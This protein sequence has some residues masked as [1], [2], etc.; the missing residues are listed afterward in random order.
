MFN[1]CNRT[2]SRA[3]V[4]V[5]HPTLW[6]RASPPKAGRPPCPPLPLRSRARVA[7]AWGAVSGTVTV[8][9]GWA[10]GVSS[11]TPTTTLRP[12]PPVSTQRRFVA[13]RLLL[14]CCVGLWVQVLFSFCS[15][16]LTFPC[17]L[18]PHYLN[19]STRFCSVHVRPFW[20]Q[21]EFYF[22]LPS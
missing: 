11:R 14:S 8:E 9:E 13:P 21:H 7:F 3:C 18:Y 17:L 10:C 19:L 1:S 12:V 22:A 2:W 16:H 15:F 20:I 5:S 4:C 6:A